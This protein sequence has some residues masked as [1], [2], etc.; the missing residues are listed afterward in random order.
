MDYSQGLPMSLARDALAFWV[1]R[2]AYRPWSIL[3]RFHRQ[4]P[5]T[6]VG[7]HVAPAVA[8]SHVPENGNVE[9]RKSSTCQDP[10]VGCCLTKAPVRPSPHTR[11][12]ESAYVCFPHSSRSH[13]ES[14]KSF[15]GAPK[16]RDPLSRRVVARRAHHIAVGH[17]HPSRALHGLPCASA[18][19]GGYRRPWWL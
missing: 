1:H 15:D 9:A 3:S 16:R 6:G 17:A 8:L 5:R 11:S 12:P 19:A 2:T 10:M 14:R 7:R 18:K 4:S 13:R